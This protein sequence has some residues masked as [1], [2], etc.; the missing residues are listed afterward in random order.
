VIAAGAQTVDMNSET[1]AIARLETDPTFAW[2]AENSEV[3]PSD[4]TF[5]R[6]LLEA[7]SLMGMVRVSR[8]LLEDS[9]NVSA[10]LE[11]AFT[12]GMAQEF[13]RAALYGTG[14]DSQPTG[15]AL[16]SSINSVSLGTDGDEL[17]GWDSLVDAVYECQVDNAETP[18]AMIY[19]PRT[20]AVIAKMKNGTGDPINMPKLIGDSPATKT[21]S[22]TVATRSRFVRPAWRPFGLPGERSSGFRTSG[23]RR[24]LR[25]TTP[26]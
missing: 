11:N 3:T 18:G 17:V 5:G 4:P 19:H 10:A 7:K 23:S 2:R 16:T 20:G 12:K 26:P 9:V 1:L 8:E 21:R 22:S 15:V 6:V 25:P 13:D 14:A 24:S